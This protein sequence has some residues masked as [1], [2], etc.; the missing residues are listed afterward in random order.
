VR[1]LGPGSRTRQYQSDFELVEVPWHPVEPCTPPAVMKASRS[2]SKRVYHIPNL[3]RTPVTFILSHP[4]AV[5]ADKQSPLI[6]NWR[7]TTQPAVY[8][9][10]NPRKEGSVRSNKEARDVSGLY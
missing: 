9:E 10:V 3:A 8:A 7:N 6:E 4:D 5:H 2:P 1:L